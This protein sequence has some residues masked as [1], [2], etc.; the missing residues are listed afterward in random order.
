MKLMER[1]KATLRVKRY[2]DSISRPAPL[3]T[4]VHSGKLL[5]NDQNVASHL[6]PNAHHQNFEGRL[7]LPQG[8]FHMLLKMLRLYA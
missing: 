6:W 7:L 1:V 2:T 5:R 4:I 8:W 3:I